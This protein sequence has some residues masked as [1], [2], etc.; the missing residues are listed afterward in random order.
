[1]RKQIDSIFVSLFFI[2]CWIFF[3]YF[4]PYHLYYKEQITLCVLQPDFLQTY[5]QKTAFLT[6]ICGDYLTQ[7]FLWTGGGSSILTL[8]FMLTWLGFRIA[9][10]KT[11][12]SSHTSLWALLPIVAEG[13]LSCHLEYPL[14]MSLGLM[15]SVWAFLLSILSTSTRMREILHVIMLTILY[16]AIGA[17]F[18]AYVILVIV[19]ECK[20]FNNYKLSFFLLLIS[21]FI[22]IGGSYFYFLTPRQSYFYPLISGYMLRQPFVFLLTEGFLLLSLLPALIFRQCK[23]CFL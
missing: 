3:F 22:P 8:T 12:I 23:Q 1:M 11:G 10:L 14:S 18:F 4:Y 2:T 20:H 16:C 17:H 19:Y 9:V 5:L 15:C 13:A 21:L 7:F 6:E